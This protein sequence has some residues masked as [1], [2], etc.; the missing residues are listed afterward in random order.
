MNRENPYS[1]TSADEPKI[2][3]SDSDTF[4][5]G[6][7]ISLETRMSLCSLQHSLDD[8]VS[9]DISPMIRSSSN[10]KKTNH[11]PMRK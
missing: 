8:S 2:D 7:Q 9:E 5:D 4:I 6:T 11:N 1:L 10:V 3:L